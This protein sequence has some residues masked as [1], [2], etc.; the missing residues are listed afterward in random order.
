[1]ALLVDSTLCLQR[2]R[3]RTKREN[4]LIV[5]TTFCLQFPRAV[6]SLHPNQH[7]ERGGGLPGM[8]LCYCSERSACTA[9]GH[10]I[11][12]VVSTINITLAHVSAKSPSII[13]TPSISKK[14]EVVFHFLTELR[15]TSSSTLVCITF[16]LG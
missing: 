4:L 7:F 12:N 15:S 5:A 3:E 14:N 16:K 8:V 9:L 13:S 6:H 11:L 10:R 1:M 2:K